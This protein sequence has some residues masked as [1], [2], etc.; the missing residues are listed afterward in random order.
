MF[1]QPPLAG[2]TSIPLKVLLTPLSLYYSR[3]LQQLRNRL[4]FPEDLNKD[5]DERAE[6]AKKMKKDCCS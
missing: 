2:C 3:G 1:F 4:F 5:A 6:E